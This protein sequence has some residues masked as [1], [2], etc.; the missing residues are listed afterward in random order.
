MA[1]FGRLSRKDKS[2]VAMVGAESLRAKVGLMRVALRVQMIKLKLQSASSVL[3]VH[4]KLFEV[5]QRLLGPIGFGY[6]LQHAGLVFCIPKNR[7]NPV[8][9]GTANS[10]D[11]LIRQNLTV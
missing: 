1:L 3:V 2:S 8:R 10:F 4:Q 11:L 6:N 7:P 5:R 9:G